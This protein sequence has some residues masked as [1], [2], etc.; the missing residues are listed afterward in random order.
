MGC[1]NC[2]S[3]KPDNSVRI[4]GD[5]KLTVN[6]AARSDTYPIPKLEDLFSQ[7]SGGAIFSKL[8]LSK[9]YAQL[10][11]DEESKPYTVINTHRGLFAYNRLSYGIT[12]APGNFQRAMEGLLK[13]LPGVFC[14]LDD[15]LISASDENQHSKRLRQVL[16]IMQDVGLRLRIE[17]CFI[18]VKKVSYLGYLIDKDGLHPTDEK[19]EAIKNAPVPTNVS[20]LKAYLGLLSFYRRFLP[21]SA[22]TLEPLHALLRN[23][24]PWRCCKIEEN[25]F[26]QSKQLLL[27]SC[28]LI[29]FDPSFP[30]VVVADS[31]AYG[32][33]A[34]LCHLIDG[35]ER[36][37]YF[38]SRTLTATERNYAQIEKEALAIVFALRKFHYY[39]WGQNFTVVTDHKPLLGLFDAGKSIPPMPSGRSYPKMVF[40][41]ASL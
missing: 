7:L 38:A 31:S 37:I 16:T 15:V 3:L 25:A 8:D 35:V 30:I 32:I 14:Y 9:A 20:Q 28:T 29:H 24:T 1:S 22:S 39:L 34:V 13:G 2:P 21:S 18:G 4:C 33:S 27:N 40:D 12:S 17:K 23:K 6:R 41:A 11:L 5:Y 36:P 26:L 10:Q 19:I